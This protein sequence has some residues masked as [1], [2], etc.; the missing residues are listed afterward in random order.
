MKKVTVNQKLEKIIKDFYYIII[1]DYNS[2][3]NNIINN[4]M[5]VS[6]NN[7]NNVLLK[8]LIYYLKLFKHSDDFID[9]IYSDK[10]LNNTYELNVFILNNFIKMDNNINNNINNNKIIFDLIFFFNK[11]I[12]LYISQVTTL[13][14]Q[15][16]LKFA[17]MF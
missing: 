5:G 14:T 7:N 13:S 3:I 15:T 6:I 16:L 12:I 9:S 17:E 1:Q 8:L 2:I 11:I 4:N 10:I